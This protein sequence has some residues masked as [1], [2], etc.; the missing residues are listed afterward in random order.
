MTVTS[1]LG[2]SN[3]SVGM[4]NINN[5]STGFTSNYTSSLT[6]SVAGDVLGLAIDFTAG[7]IWIS[8][9]NVWSNSSNPTTGTLPIVSFVQATVGALFPRH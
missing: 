7:S 9:N 6:P 2:A 3:Y 5:V 1:Y 8:K 4:G